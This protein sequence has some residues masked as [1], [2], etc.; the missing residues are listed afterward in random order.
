MNSV[1]STEVA[2]DGNAGILPSSTTVS[3]ACRRNALTLATFWAM[4]A[5]QHAAITKVVVDQVSTE[6]GHRA[7]IT[8]RS[9]PVNKFNFGHD[10]PMHAEPPA[11]VDCDSVNT[12]VISDSSPADA[13]TQQE[14]VP[15]NVLH[16]DDKVKIWATFDADH[17]GSIVRRWPPMVLP[18]TWE[19]Y[20]TGCKFTL[21]FAV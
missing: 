3:K 12:G 19:D 18:F 8:V 4:D 14:L 17:T 9:Y 11:A 7:C 13:D 6:R 21:R 2:A 5:T 10:D 16:N 20:P 15:P 1:Q